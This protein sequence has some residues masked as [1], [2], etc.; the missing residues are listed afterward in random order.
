[1][2]VLIFHASTGNGHMSAAL[3]LEEEFRARGYEVACHDVLDYTPPGFC[4][5]YRGGYEFLVKQKPDIWGD[6]YEKADEEGFAYSFQTSLDHRF[7][8]GIDPLVLEGKPKWV[9]VTH[10]LPLPRLSLLRRR[11]RFFKIGTVITDLY[12]HKMWLRGRPDHFFVMSDWSKEQLGLRSHG[13]EART[14]VTGIPIAACFSEEMSQSEARRRTGLDED[15]P[16]ALL[17]AGGIGAGPMMPLLSA[18]ARSGIPVQAVVVCGRNEQARLN[19]ESRARE[20]ERRSKTKIRVLGQVSQ[21]GMAD[22]MNACDVLIGKSGGL[23]TSEAMATGCP[24]LVA[25]PFLIP[26][27]EEGNADFMVQAGIGARA[28]T[29][30]EAAE[31]LVFLLKSPDRLDQMR[32]QALSHAHPKAAASIADKVLAMSDI[33]KP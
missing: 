19:L 14:T 5:W 10:S 26:G 25:D 28:A 33:K 20:L 8:K 4:A 31:H 30:E 6:I 32:S 16:V 1:M 18:M 12:P 21:Q 29:P 22:L 17:T 11:H 7:C 9:L 13:A 27:Q 2:D 3:A 23:T 15:L 24:F